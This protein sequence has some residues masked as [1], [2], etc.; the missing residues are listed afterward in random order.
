MV[1]FHFDVR[2]SI[3]DGF[4]PLPSFKDGRG[5]LPIRKVERGM[6]DEPVSD[7]LRQF[8]LE[9]I[10]SIVQLEALLLL[11]KHPGQDW[12][13]ASAALRLY[14]TD[15]VAAEA[16]AQLHARG[17]LVSDGKL[18]RYGPKTAAQ[19]EMLDRLADTYA[20]SLISVTDIVH[21]N[22]RGLRKFAGPFELRKNK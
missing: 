6:T 18:Y 20:R 9:H 3:V 15:E 4:L 17:L 1:M 2:S 10:D 21:G 7:D 16:L 22:L 13:V 11:R 19:A 14:V 8:T 5:S 12:H